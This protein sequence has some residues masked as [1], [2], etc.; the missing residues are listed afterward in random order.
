MFD[1]CA[2]KMCI[3]LDFVQKIKKMNVPPIFMMIYRRKHTTF[4][5]SKTQYRVTFQK[6]LVT[7]YEYNGRTPRPTL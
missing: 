3:F 4:E 1:V 2:A 6:S 5:R 7:Y